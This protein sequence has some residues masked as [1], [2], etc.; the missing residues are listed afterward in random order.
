MHAWKP[1]P[2]TTVRRRAVVGLL[3]L[4]ALARAGRCW[5]QSGKVRYD[6]RLFD[7]HLHLNWENGFHLPVDEAFALMRAN[8]VTTIL[9]TSRPN[10]GTRGLVEGAQGAKGVRVVPFLR[11]Y[12]VRSDVQSWSTDPTTLTLLEEE[13]RRGYYVGVGEFHLSGD[14]AASD[15]VRRTV[16]FARQRGLWLHAHV[17]DAALEILY[18]HDPEAKIVWA[19]TGFSTPTEMVAAYLRAH[20]QLVGELSYRY[21]IT[22]DGGRLTAEWRMLFEAFPERFLI[23]SDTWILQR[24]QVYGELMEGYRA[25]LGQLPREVADRIAHGN[26]ERLFPA[27]SR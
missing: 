21:G 27:L 5:A 14:A 25:W 20:P 13:Y 8:G 22:G 16:Q 10:D 4:L 17:D 26:G 2:G 3:P 15:V 9:A 18:R 1:D 11:P 7:G 23:G 12:R 19:H 24:W 6:G